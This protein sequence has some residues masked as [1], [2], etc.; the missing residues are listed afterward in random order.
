[1]ATPMERMVLE[2]N[3]PFLQY[4]E[5]VEFQSVAARSGWR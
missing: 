4:A 3:T 5:L 1:M 2:Q